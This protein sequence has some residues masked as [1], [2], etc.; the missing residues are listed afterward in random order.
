MSMKITQDRMKISN[1]L[2]D[3]TFNIEIVDLYHED[4]TSAGTE[5]IIK[6]ITG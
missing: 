6:V 5:A 4:G 2:S 1:Q 3:N